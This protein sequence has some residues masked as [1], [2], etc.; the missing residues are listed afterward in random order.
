MTT[1]LR[2]WGNSMAV[3]IPKTVMRK[4][5]LRAGEE[6]ELVVTKPGAVELR[7][8]K[9]R[10]KKQKSNPTLKELMRRVTPENVHPEV[11]WGPPVGKEI[12]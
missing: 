9:R 6:L 7:R 11:D 12:W 5:R 2:K 10:A 3:R 4:A 8:R 1:R